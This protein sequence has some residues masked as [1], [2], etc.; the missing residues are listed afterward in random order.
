LDF[1]FFT[2]FEP[3]IYVLWFISC[4]S[5][6]ALGFMVVQLIASQLMM[7][8]TNATTL[9]SMKKKAMAP[10]PFIEWRPF[11]HKD[12]MVLIDL[13]RSIHLT[14]DKYKICDHFLELTF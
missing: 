3:G 12:S 4:L 5:A 13:R 9:D 14:E 7:I 2:V 1:N 10:I 8:C 11:H 6:A